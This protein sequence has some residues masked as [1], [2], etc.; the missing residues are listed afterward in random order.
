MPGSS[1]GGCA[2]MMTSICNSEGLSTTQHPWR[3]M[4][5]YTT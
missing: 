2:W 4:S 3:G 5:G 1:G